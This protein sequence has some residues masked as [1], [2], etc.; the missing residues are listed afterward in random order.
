VLD[1]EGVLVIGLDGATFDLLDPLMDAGVMPVLRNLIKTGSAG[2]LESTIPPVS[3]PAWVSFQT[4]VNPGKHGIVDFLRYRPGSYDPVLVNSQAIQNR[5]LWAILSEHGRRMCVVNV[6]MTYPPQPVNGCLVTGLLTP[7]IDT[8]FT[9]P[10]GLREQLLAQV[11]DYVIVPPMDIAVSDVGA[12]VE[13]MLQTIRQR[14]K[15]AKWLMGQGSWDLFM[16][17]FQAVDVLQHAYWDRLDPAHPNFAEYPTSEQSLVQQFYHTLDQVIGDLVQLADGA[18]I[19]LMSDHGF[20]PADKCIYLNRW[21]VDQ[22]YLALSTSDWWMQMQAGT[23]SLL[24]GLDV[25]GLRHRLFPKGPGKRRDSMIRRLAQDPWTDW[26]RTRA[27]VPFGTTYASLYLNRTGR[28]PSGTVP[29]SKVESLRTELTEC[30][31]TL[32]DPDTDQPIIDQ[33]YKREEVF[34]GPMLPELPDLIVRPHWGYL[35]Q[36]RFKGTRLFEPMPKSVTGLHR[37]DGIHILTGGDFVAREERDRASILDL[38]PTILHLLGVPVP[39][40][41]DGRILVETMDPSHQMPSER[42][43]SDRET[44]PDLQTSAGAY[45]PEEESEVIDRLR[46]LG[47]L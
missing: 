1:K 35:V 46:E 2:L 11:P 4:G 37:M 22:G 39:E 26:K 10:A 25:L 23:E 43:A 7:G 36:T 27:Y 24:K 8:R 38:A 3:A 19:I 14:W 6:P 28:E 12:F 41:M 16:V 29:E 13:G 15:A 32:M 42:A 34:S 47:Y 33:V 31:Q 9:H 45:T 18:S 17:H 44:A 20:G 5:T 21:L 40:W 30:F